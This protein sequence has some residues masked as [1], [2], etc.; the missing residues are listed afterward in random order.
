MTQAELR[1]DGARP[2]VRLERQ[3]ADPP[4]VVW[5]AIT[6]RAQ[7]RAWFPCD[8]LVA[9]GVWEVGTSITF[10]FGPE[11]GEMTLTGEVFEVDEPNLLAFSWGEE[12]L[13]FHLTPHGSGTHFVLTDELPPD[14]A[15]RNAAGWDDC[16]DRLAGL[17]PGDW[18][19]RFNAYAAT[20][21]PLVGP[22]SGPPT[23]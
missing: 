20:F 17:E 12:R 1:T 22:Q 4:S 16:L 19:S 5:Q 7:L 2:V 13:R 3:L 18:Q 23:A 11:M 14:A 15:A 10:D 9:G 21:E 8:V 6:E